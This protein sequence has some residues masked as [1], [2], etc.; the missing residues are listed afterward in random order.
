MT[1]AADDPFSL[2]FAEM[3]QEMLKASP[4]LDGYMQKLK[5]ELAAMPELV[6]K[7]TPEQIGDIVSGLSVVS[8]IAIVSSTGGK[9]TKS[10]AGALASALDLLS[11]DSGGK[12]PKPPSAAE[13]KASADAFANLDL[14]QIDTTKGP[15]WRNRK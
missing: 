13:L 4:N 1:L 10:D 14:S 12:M 7:L 2:L 15:T 11:L 3:K 8:R 9:K 6:W 5:N